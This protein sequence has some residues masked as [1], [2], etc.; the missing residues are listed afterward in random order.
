MIATNMLSYKSFSSACP[1]NKHEKAS[2]ERISQ[3]EGNFMPL[4]SFLLL[5]IKCIDMSNT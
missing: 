2:K 4:K 1:N 3:A 5:N